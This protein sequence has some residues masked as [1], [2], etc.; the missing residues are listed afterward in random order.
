MKTIKQPKKYNREAYRALP[1]KVTANISAKERT[2]LKTKL[3]AQNMTMQ[4]LIR[5]KIQEFIEK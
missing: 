3:A 4:E 5:S 1:C 2:D